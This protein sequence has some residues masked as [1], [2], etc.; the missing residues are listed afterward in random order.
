MSA[1]L[2]YEQRDTPRGVFREAAVYET[3]EEALL[4]AAWDELSGGN[5]FPERIVAGAHHGSE[6]WRKPRRGR[7]RYT[8]ETESAHDADVKVLADI[9][10]IER[11]CKIVRKHYV[12]HH[13]DVSDPSLPGYGELMGEP[14]AVDG[15]GRATGWKTTGDPEKL[16]RE[17]GRLK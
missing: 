8:P 4:Q 2:I 16:L 10:K 7:P 12:V 3:L 17:L 13:E 6:G 15:H 14:S 9:K 1:T 11:A 5:R